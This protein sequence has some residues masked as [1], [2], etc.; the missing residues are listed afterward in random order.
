MKSKAVRSFVLTRIGRQEPRN[1]SH[2]KRTY[3]RDSAL[4]IFG[5][6]DALDAPIADFRDFWQTTLPM[7]VA[8][9]AAPRHLDD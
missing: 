9:L 5:L 7:V 3:L 6:R 2:P 4:R 1:P 8:A